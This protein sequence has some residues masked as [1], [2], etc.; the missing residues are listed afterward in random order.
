[1]RFITFLAM[2]ASL[3][4]GIQIN[5][6]GSN[7]TITKGSTVSI[8]FDTVNTDPTTFGVYLVNFVNWPPYYNLLTANAETSSKSVSVKIPCKLDSVYG[9]QL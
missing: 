3:A 7:S 1:M 5:S 6:P 9:Y 4:A 8:P 2:A